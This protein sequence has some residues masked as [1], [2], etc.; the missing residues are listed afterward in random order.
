MNH[1]WWRRAAHVTECKT[2]EAATGMATDAINVSGGNMIGGQTPDCGS[3]DPRLARTMATNTTARKARVIHRRYCIGHHKTGERGSR[4]ALGTRGRTN[5]HVIGRFNFGCWCTNPG[6]ALSVTDTAANARNHRMIHRGR[7]C[8]TG[9]CKL[10][11]CEVAGRV[12]TLAARRSKRNMATR[13]CHGGRRTSPILT[14]PMTGSASHP[15]D[16]GMNHRWRS[17][18]AGVGKLETREICG[19]VAGDAGCSTKRHVVRR[20]LPQRWRGHVCKTLTARMAGL[21][22]R[23]DLGMVHRVRSKGIRI[24]VTRGAIGRRAISKWDMVR[25]IIRSAFK[26]SRRLVAIRTLTGCRMHR[27]GSFVQWT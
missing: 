18:T 12:A 7:R 10:E 6:H 5:R 4:M 16:T 11:S 8:T 20:W 27:T 1:G 3:T 14:H 9:I 21:A 25:R 24:R 13:W 19:R 23:R 26:G 15:C 17:R 22:H 2:V